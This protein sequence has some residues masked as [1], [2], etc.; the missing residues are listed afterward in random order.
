MR[1]SQFHA[2][3]LGVAQDPGQRH[4]LLQTSESHDRVAWYK[5][6]HAKPTDITFLPLPRPD[7]QHDELD[8]AGNHSLP[9][10]GTLG[11]PGRPHHKQLRRSLVQSP[12]V[13]ILAIPGCSFFFQGK[14]K[15]IKGKVKPGLLV[16]SFILSLGRLGQD[17]RELEASLCSIKECQK[18]TSKQTK[19]PQTYTTTK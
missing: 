18:Q 11:V 9:V 8:I 13:L 17:N 5:E 19:R 16:Y 12:V 10:S 1:M 6:K 3:L 4:C 2:A 14:G 15:K 7:T